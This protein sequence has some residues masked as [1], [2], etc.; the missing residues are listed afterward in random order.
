MCY[1]LITD[2]INLVSKTS[3]VRVTIYYYLIPGFYFRVGDYNKKLMER[4]YDVNFQ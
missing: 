3:V 4:L 2:I 1:W